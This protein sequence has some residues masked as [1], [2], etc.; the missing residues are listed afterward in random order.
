MQL[1]YLREI[2]WQKSMTL[3]SLKS[4]ERYS[5]DLLTLGLGEVLAL[6]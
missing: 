4:C 3:L 6:A 5:G 2:G 1:K